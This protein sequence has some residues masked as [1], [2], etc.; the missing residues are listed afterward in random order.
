[1]AAGSLASPWNL[2]NLDGPSRNDRKRERNQKATG[3]GRRDWP[4]ARP[5][6]RRP[7]ALAPRRKVER[8]ANECDFAVFPNHRRET[9]QQLMFIHRSFLFFFL[10]RLLPPSGARSLHRFHSFV[11]FSRPIPFFLFSFHPRSSEALLVRTKKRPS[12]A[13]YVRRFFI[14]GSD[15]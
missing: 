14:S 4:A 1:M 8:L 9:A 5:I 15:N 7:R 12:I 10:P 6:T 13:I 2:G 3:A 11:F